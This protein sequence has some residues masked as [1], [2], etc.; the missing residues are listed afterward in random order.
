MKLDTDPFPVGMVE[1]KHKKIL[2]RIGQA[3]TTKV[4]TW[5]FLTDDTTN[6]T[7]AR[8]PIA[9]V[10]HEVEYNPNLEFQ[11]GRRL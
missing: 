10:A 2:V 1:I 8:G 5:S 6:V 11:S 4:R 7:W 3:E 9:T